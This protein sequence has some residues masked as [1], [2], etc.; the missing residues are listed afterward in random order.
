MPYIKLEDRAKF[1]DFI[2]GMEDSKPRGA[3]ELNF[4]LTSV[5]H[6][7]LEINGLRYQTLADIE[8][9]LAGASKEFY[10]RVTA[11]YEDEKIAENGD[12]MPLIDR[13]WVKE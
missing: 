3:G 11:K 7:Y 10:R 4:L 12:L 8:A 2:A 6:H 5:V 9:A 1:Y 13:P